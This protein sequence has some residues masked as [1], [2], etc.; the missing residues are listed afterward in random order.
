[1]GGRCYC[2]SSSDATVVPFVS[3]YFVTVLTM[4]NP[5]GSTDTP[6]KPLLNWVGG[7]RLL[8]ARLKQLLPADILG[9]TYREPFL[10]AASLFFALRPAKAVLSDLN[11]HLITCYESV[12]DAPSAV[13]AY[14]RD[15]ARNNTEDYYYRIRDEY[16]Q[17]N[18]S[19]AQASRFIYLNKT[20]F[21]G[22]FRVNRKGEFNVPFG[23]K[24]NP[25]FP[26]RRWL[27]EA[28]DA[29]RRSELLTVPFEDALSTV[30]KGDFVYLDPPYPPINGTSYFTH[31][32]ADRFG[33]DSQRRLASLV[34]EIDRKGALFMMT[35]ADT[36]LIRALYNEKRFKFA[37][38]SVTR[39]VTCKAKRYRIGELV[40]T[41]YV[42]PS[43][44][45][46]QHSPHR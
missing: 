3:R 20:C 44:V 31:Y 9:R 6:V 24:S 15:H 41:N 12:R 38:L 4:P 22:V 11:E 42:P 29:L 28:G 45:A 36:D 34:K 1:M 8:V 46:E 39:Y 2:F 23:D 37:E 18:F 26:D 35:N 13:A 10:G 21:N 17:R 25:I 40:I 30:Q 19:A 7:K 43:G 32:T 16:N 5:L 27:E 14:L 33:E